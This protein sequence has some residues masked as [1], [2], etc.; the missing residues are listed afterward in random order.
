MIK[1]D[2][3]SNRFKDEIGDLVIVIVMLLIFHVSS[4][5]I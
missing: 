1:K 4:M 5:P 2:I 3:Y